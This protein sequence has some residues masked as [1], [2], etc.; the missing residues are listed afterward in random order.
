MVGRTW[1]A[2]L[3][4]G[5]PLVSHAQPRAAKG[6]VIAELI[7]LR[8]DNGQ[9]LAAMFRSADGFPSTPSKAFARKAAHSKQ[10]KLSLVFDGVPAG[11]FAIS[12]F[13]DENNNNALEKTF[14]GIPREGWGMSRD[15]KPGLG[16]PS[17]DDARLTLAPGEHKHILIHIRY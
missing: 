2:I 11:P 10:K 9:V 15:A 16:P 14:I 13:H 12:V 6:Q 1:I 4:L 3:C 8:N 17:F 5:L 7:G